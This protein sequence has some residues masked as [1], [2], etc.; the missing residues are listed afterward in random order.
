MKPLITNLDFQSTSEKVTFLLLSDIHFDNPKC[1]RDILKR[2]LDEAK[3]HGHKVAINGDFFCLMQGKA[4]PRH[5]KGD[6]RPEHMGGNYFD[7]V[8]DTAVEWWTPYADMIEFIGYGNHETAVI[9]RGETDVLKR[10]V[11]KINLITGS[12]IQLGGY[13]GWWVIA[14]K[15]FS[16]HSSYKVKYHHGYGGGGIVTKGIIQNQR[17]DASVEGADCIWMGHVHEAYHSITIKDVIETG[18]GYVIRQKRVDHIRTPAFK[19]EYTD[20]GFH[21][22]KGRPPKPIGC[23]KM[24]V[25]FS[26]GKL[27]ARFQLLLE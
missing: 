3:K 10:F 17:A 11:E 7:L 9:K 16:T 14:G 1:E 20:G 6:V 5:T 8:V 25:Y 13:H 18:K 24:D 4:D 21:I 2:Y 19:Q 22:E 15:Y 23:A 26:D 12:K 27:D